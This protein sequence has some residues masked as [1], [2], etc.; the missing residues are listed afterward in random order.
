MNEKVYEKAIKLLSVRLHTTGEL[1]R[2]L[3]TKGFDAD[4]IAEVLRRLE[5][6][7]FLNDQRFAEIFVDNLKRYKD[8]GYYGIK[9]KLAQRQIPGDIAAAALAEFFTPEDEMVVA[10]RLLRKLSRPE[11]SDPSRPILNRTPIRVGRTPESG[12]ERSA[13]GGKKL[14]KQKKTAY[15]KLSAAFARRGFRGETVRK[16]LTFLG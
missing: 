2:K 5:E 6:L 10:Q 4:D 9:A 15:E 11:S 12:S 13:S 16:A 1:Q 14:Q 3:K 8:W 7:D